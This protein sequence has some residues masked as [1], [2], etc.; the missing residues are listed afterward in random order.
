MQK[1][2]NGFLSRNNLSSTVRSTAVNESRNTDFK[3]S[4][5]THLDGSKS[6]NQPIQSQYG[7]TL[8]VPNTKV[9]LPVSIFM[10]P[11]TISPSR[12]AIMSTPKSLAVSPKSSP[13]SLLSTETQLLLAVTMND[14]Q[15]PKTIIT[16]HDHRLLLN[17]RMTT[18]IPTK[19]SQQPKND[20]DKNHHQ[21][22]N[23]RPPK[24]LATNEPLTAFFIGSRRM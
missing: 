20:D 4:N 22:I 12:P 2:E 15:K 3:I 10:P 21:I 9:S 13:T 1:R 23:E 6:T 24:K 18:V 7:T 5:L 8:N 16:P 19:Q 11:A 14:Q 17:E